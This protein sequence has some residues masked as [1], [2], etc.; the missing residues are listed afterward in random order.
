MLPVAKFKPAK[1]N[2]RI[3]ISFLLCFAILASSESGAAQSAKKG[4]SE[5][6]PFSIAISAAHEVVSAGAPIPAVVTFTNTSSHDIG[7]LRAPVEFNFKIDVHDSGGNRPSLADGSK[8][9]TEA[10]ETRG[11]S[12]PVAPGEALKIDFEIDKACDWSK[13]GAYTIQ[14]SR[15][16]EAAKR[17][18][19][20]NIITVTVT[21]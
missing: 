15:M 8:V 1:E 7:I 10:V 11:F 5:A 17:I 20:S 14:L 2:M 6:P 18:A 9:P 12:I 16:D 21:K 4:K 13:P 3:S 19:K